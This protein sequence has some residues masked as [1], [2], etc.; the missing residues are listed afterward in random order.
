VRGFV[1]V[2]SYKGDKTSL[3]FC[4]KAGGE[5]VT[6]SHVNPIKF[7]IVGEYFF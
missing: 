6:D 7:L 2:F 4:T 5:I 1:L 3:I